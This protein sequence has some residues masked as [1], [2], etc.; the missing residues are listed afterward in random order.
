MLPENNS[1][2]TDLKTGNDTDLN[3]R[4]DAD[5]DEGDNSDNDLQPQ[6][7]V[8]PTM[9]ALFRNFKEN[10]CS[11]ILKCREKDNIPQTVQ[12]EIL[13]D[14]IFCFVILSKITMLLLHTILKKMGSVFWSVLN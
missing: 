12:Q 9:D 8:P 6:A 5:L 1:S 4:N 2:D 11:F 7:D 10:L 13:N 14:L 3:N